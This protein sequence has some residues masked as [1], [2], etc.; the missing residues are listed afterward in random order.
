MGAPTHAAQR[1]R[2]V[3]NAADLSPF[4]TIS[5]YGCIFENLYLW[6]GQD[7]VHS[8]VLCSVTGK[9]NY[10][11]GVHFAGGGHATQAIDAG[12]SRADQ[13]RGAKTSSSGA[14]SVWT[15]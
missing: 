8:L 1:T 2:I 3:C 11:R 15:R 14:R 4:L 9:R 6:Q 13:W 10:F 12:A 7:D 5:A